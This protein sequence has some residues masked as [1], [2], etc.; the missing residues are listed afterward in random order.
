MVFFERKG[1]RDMDPV[2]LLVCLTI[3]LFCFTTVYWM[4]A[5]EKKHRYEKT[6][7]VD[8]FLQKNKINVNRFFSGYQTDLIHDAA[9]KS[10]W[11]FELPFD[12]LE[13]K[14]ISYDDIY[15]VDYKL[16]GVVIDSVMKQGP[17]KRELLSSNPTKSLVEFQSFIQVKDK[18]RAAKEVKLT[19]LLDDLQGT[20][21]DVVFA[22]HYFPK[23]VKRMKNNDALKWFNIFKDAV[24]NNVKVEEERKR[25]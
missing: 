12:Q 8:L 14:N 25:A 4:K 9:T 2:T 20:A 10:F 23:E 17:S 6:K 15:R 7:R 19:I 21:L 16:D 1:G 24:E 3:A 11:Y 5:E 18:V 22:Q 13:Y